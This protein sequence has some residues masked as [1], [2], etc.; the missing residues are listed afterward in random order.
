MSR[1]KMTAALA[2]AALALALLAVVTLFTG[3]MPSVAAGKRTFS[4]KVEVKRIDIGLGEEVAQ[5]SIL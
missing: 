3:A 4:L 1:R 5:I 2:A